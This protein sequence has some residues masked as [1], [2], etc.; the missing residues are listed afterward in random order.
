MQINSAVSY[1]SKSWSF[2]T[3]FCVP[4]QINLIVAILIQIR[5]ILFLFIQETVCQIPLSFKM[6]F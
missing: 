6:Y 4:F 2:L 5:E 1:E 3:S